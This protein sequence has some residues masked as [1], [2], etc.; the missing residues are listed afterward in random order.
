[1]WHEIETLAGEH[2]VTVLLT[3][4]YM[5]EADRLAARLAI[6]DQGRI[7]AEGT[8]DELK[9]ELR[10]DAVH[11]ELAAAANGSARA[12]LDRLEGVREVVVDGQT[13]HARADDGARAVPGVLAALD[14]NGVQVASVT[15]ARPSLEDVYL[16]HAGRTF[17]EAAR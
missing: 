3:T 1:M 12:A 16:R 10:G 7:V 6:V 5:E 11:V 9:R 8:P 13:V 14:A 17:E 4:H 2:G 15:V